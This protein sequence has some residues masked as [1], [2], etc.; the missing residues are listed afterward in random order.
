MTVVDTVKEAV[1]LGEGGPKT[2]TYT[3]LESACK[4]EE[5]GAIHIV[6][7]MGRSDI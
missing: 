4:L 7:G 1:G 3:Q 6:A 2:R 5:E